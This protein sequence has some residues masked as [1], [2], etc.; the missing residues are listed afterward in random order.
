MLQTK[1]NEL[2]QQ[3]GGIMADNRSSQML[4]DQDDFNEENNFMKAP[5]STA[6]SSVV[7]RSAAQMSIMSG[8]GYGSTINSGMSRANNNSL[9]FRFDRDKREQL[10]VRYIYR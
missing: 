4:L 1:V 9:R 5:G 6:N 2:K 7:P 3:I 8:S 10:E